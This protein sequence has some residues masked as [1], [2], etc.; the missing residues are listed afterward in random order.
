[1]E[2]ESGSEKDYMEERNNIIVMIWQVMVEMIWSR[3][4]AIVF[5]Y[6]FLRE[7]VKAV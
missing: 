6:S 5:S 7:V 4:W 3:S 1:M 2:S